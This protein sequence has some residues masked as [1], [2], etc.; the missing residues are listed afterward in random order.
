M[1]LIEIVTEPH[2]ESSKEAVAFLEELRLILLYLGV[3]DCRMEEGS[4]RCD[5]NLSVRPK[6]QTS[7]GVRTEMKNLN[8]FRAVYRAIEL[9]LIHI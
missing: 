7:L 9:S 2:I 8:S 5:V 3:S 6:G 4:L 1:P